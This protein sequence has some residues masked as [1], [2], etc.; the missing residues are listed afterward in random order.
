MKAY[1]TLVHNAIASGFVVSVFDGEEWPVKRSVKSNDIYA[2]I[3]S[4]DEAQLRI[5][6]KDGA[7]IG[8]A[9]VVNGLEDDELV[10]DYTDNT[11]MRGLIGDKEI[12]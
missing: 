9:L 11:I 4:V 12:V 3:E 1:K 7:Y 10:A 8:W 2:A 5:R 6:D